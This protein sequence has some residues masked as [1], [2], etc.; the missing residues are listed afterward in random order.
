MV[1]FKK[2]ISLHVC[3]KCFCIYEIKHIF[4]FNK[5]NNLFI[6]EY[7]LFIYFKK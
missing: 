2:N 6:D 3:K 1:T 7:Y 5:H 4:L